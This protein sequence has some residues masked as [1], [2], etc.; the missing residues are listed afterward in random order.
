MS[1]NEPADNVHKKTVDEPETAGPG[2]SAKVL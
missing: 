2:L 1:G